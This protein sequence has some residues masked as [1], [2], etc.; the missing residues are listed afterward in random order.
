MVGRGSG[1]GGDGSPEHALVRLG[2]AS[3]SAA[4]AETA[5]FPIDTTKTIMQ[6]L[7]SSPSKPRVGAVRVFSEI[8]RRQGLLALYSG[9]SPAVVRHLIYTSIRITTYERLRES[10]LHKA[11]AGGISGVVGQVS[12][13]PYPAFLTC[14]L[15]STGE[16]ISGRFRFLV[17][18]I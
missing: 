13:L 6:L 7:R 11:L 8:V 16:L 9:W 14:L 2:L 5:T 12:S 17:G 4:V 3:A 18:L 10:S 1:G 15:P